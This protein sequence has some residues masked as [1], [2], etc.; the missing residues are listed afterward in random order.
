M[1]SPP[2]PLRPLPGSRPD[3]PDHP[4]QRLLAS[5]ATLVGALHHSNLLARQ[6]HGQLARN[7]EGHGRFWLRL[8]VTDP[9]G[10]DVAWSA[11]NG[12]PG[13]PLPVPG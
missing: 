2:P 1:P 3:Q 11:P 9:T 8:V 12:G 7:G 6:T 5:S 10:R 4:S 13:H